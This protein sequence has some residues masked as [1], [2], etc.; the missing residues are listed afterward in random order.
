VTE[1][2]E[3]LEEEV[4]EVKVTMV[5]EEVVIPLGASGTAFEGMAV[6]DDQAWIPWNKVVRIL[7]GIHVQDVLN[8]I[9]QEKDSC[10]SDQVI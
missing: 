3:F 2:F 5:V 8:T 1:I 7:Q 10:S 6:A 4:M 9:L